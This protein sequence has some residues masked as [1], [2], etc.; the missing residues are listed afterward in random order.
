MCIRDRYICVCAC[1]NIDEEIVNLSR[2]EVLSSVGQ[3]FLKFIL[4]A[5]EF[6]CFLSQNGHLQLIAQFL[7]HQKRE[8]F[9]FTQGDADDFEII[10]NVKGLWVHLNCPQ[11]VLSL[12]L[13]HI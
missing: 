6:V 5:I 8:E 10:P 7:F 4:Q 3:F 12:S 11:I 2:L 1:I 9:N 13:I